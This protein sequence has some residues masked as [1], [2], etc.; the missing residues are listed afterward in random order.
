MIT[1]NAEL[2]K[3][4]PSWLYKLGSQLFM[5][6]KWPRHLFI[7][8]TAACNLACEYCPREKI[9]NHMDFGLFRQI[10]DEASAYGPRSF[11]L[12][13]F[14]EPLLYPRIID[15]IRYIKKRNRRNTILFTTNGTLLGRFIDDLQEVDKIIWSWRPEAT[16]SD[17]TRRKLKATKGFTV[18]LIKEVVPEK[19]FKEWARW[20]KVEVRSVH[21]Y[22]GNIDTTKYAAQSTAA[23]R[24]PCY[25]LWLAPAVSWNG[26]HLICCADPHQKE[27]IGTFPRTSV[28]DSWKKMAGIRQAHL[29]GKFTGICENC[30]VW[31]S[32]PN[33]FFKFQG[34]YANS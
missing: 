15:A 21:N 17:D 27:I 16:F 12:H 1:D 20:P 3:R 9:K 14:G 29:Q 5:D 24:Y 4:L 11:S 19:D 6:N 30:D 31:K 10:I 28:A 7:E 23:R 34:S 18:R 26:N 8:T 32:Y 25:H 2:I 22:G 13:L 33:M